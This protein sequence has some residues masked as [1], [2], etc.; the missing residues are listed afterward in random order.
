MTGRPAVFGPLGLMNNIESIGEDLCAIYID[1][2]TTN[3]RAWLVRGGE[4][5]A[6]ANKPVRYILRQSLQLRE[7]RRKSQMPEPVN[8][9][10]NQE[11]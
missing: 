2:G 9:R 10:I 5:V 8:R 4:V 11:I 3:T 1:M 6:R 7:S